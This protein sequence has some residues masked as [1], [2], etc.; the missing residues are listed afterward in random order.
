VLSLCLHLKPPS[1]RFC[2]DLSV[3]RVRAERRSKT[4]ARLLVGLGGIIWK[5]FFIV[6]LTIMIGTKRKRKTLADH[7]SFLLA[8][9]HTTVDPEDDIYPGRLVYN[10]RNHMEA[11]F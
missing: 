6:G 10:L 4:Q 11:S 8:E 7:I 5:V 1:K 2:L 9:H 3:N